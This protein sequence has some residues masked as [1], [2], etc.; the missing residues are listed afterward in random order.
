[1]QNILG[2]DELL[3]TQ[4]IRSHLHHPAAADLQ[5]QPEN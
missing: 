4:Q 3:L 2:F 5:W 1:M